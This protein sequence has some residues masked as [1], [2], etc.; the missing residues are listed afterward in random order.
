MIF[1]IRMDQK[2]ISNI[3]CYVLIFNFIFVDKFILLTLNWST[4]QSPPNPPE[5]SGSSVLPE[6]VIDSSCVKKRKISDCEVT[7]ENVKKGNSS[8]RKQLKEANNLAWRKWIQYQNVRDP[9]LSRFIVMRDNILYLDE[10]ME[11]YEN[12]PKMEHECTRL[13]KLTV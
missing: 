13:N 9:K 2:V 7:S 1:I 6:Q 4:F 12:L 3:L 5:A 8:Y 11:I 10:E